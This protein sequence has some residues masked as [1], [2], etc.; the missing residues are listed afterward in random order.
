MRSSAVAVK[1]ETY[2]DGFE[3]VPIERSTSDEDIVRRV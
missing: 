2:V 3:L 1:S